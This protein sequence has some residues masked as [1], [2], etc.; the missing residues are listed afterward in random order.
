MARI[1]EGE[2]SRS[3]FVTFV[4]VLG[5]GEEQSNFPTAAP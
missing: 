3:S 2:K 4:A 5:S 1:L